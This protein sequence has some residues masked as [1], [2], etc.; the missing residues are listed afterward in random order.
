MN[1]SEYTID[2]TKM[3][4]DASRESTVYKEAK[5]AVKVLF[6]LLTYEE[7]EQII[8]IVKKNRTEE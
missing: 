4:S 5:E 1:T 2:I 6:E 8:E 7:Q 3:H